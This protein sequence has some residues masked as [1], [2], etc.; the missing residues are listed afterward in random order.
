MVKTETIKITNLLVNTENFRFEPVVSQQE[1]IDKMVEEQGVKLVELA[2]DI[3]KNGLNPN[4][5]IQICKSHHDETKYNVLE[6]NR[7]I[8]SL[9]LLFNPDILDNRFSN[10]KEKFKK[11]HE[12]FK[13]QLFTEVECN[14]YDDPKDA[15]H[16]I[17]IKHGYDNNGAGTEKWDAFSK[18]RYEEEVLGKSNI[19][20]QAISLIKKSPHISKDIK[21]NISDIK[22]TNLH[23]LVSDPFVREFLGLEYKK[24][25]LSS[26]IDEKELAKGLEKVALDC[27]NKKF[28]VGEI[29]SKDDR[30][31]YIQKFPE[32]N[33]PDKTKKPSGEKSEEADQKKSGLTSTSIQQ[34]NI[35]RKRLIPASCKISIKNPK[36][37]A[38]Y[39]ELRKMEVEKYT[40]A[41]AVLFRVFVELSL[42]SF[43]EDKKMTKGPSAAKE[44]NL[45]LHEKLNKV[46]S[47]LTSKKLIDGAIS[48]G[49]E[50]A[51]SNKNDLLGIDTWHA[52]VHNNRF[53]PNAKDL[54]ITWDNIQTFIERLWGELK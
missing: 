48:K 12:K 29:Y 6:G 22:L 14:Y 47:Y 49:I 34:K 20:S 18:T 17:G 53:S 40:N 51:I 11:I 45:K 44:A 37:N 27:L 10:I 52:Y 2:E 38:I 16:W 32:K 7:R 54:I 30:K 15:E 46:K 33:I 42:D 3:M 21:E 4:D 8:V 5:K 35:Q 9:K 19:V 39:N 26:N 1:A 41:V 36:T 31:D 23:R 50:V 13:N 24:G 43:L 28:T 25:V